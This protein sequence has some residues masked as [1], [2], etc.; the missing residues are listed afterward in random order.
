[1][2]TCHPRP[3]AL[4]CVL[5]SALPRPQRWL[6]AR[7]CPLRRATSC[8]TGPH[9]QHAVCYDCGT[10]RLEL[11]PQV[12]FDKLGAGQN[13]TVAVMSFSGCGGGGVWLH[14]CLMCTPCLLV[15]Q[16]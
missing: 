6:G 9:V 3:R 13:A 2:V 15:Q 16:P 11:S 5:L 14:G 8:S 4:P 1:M 10:L 7:T 12:G